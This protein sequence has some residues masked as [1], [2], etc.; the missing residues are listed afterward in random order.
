[1]LLAYGRLLS[2]FAYIGLLGY[3]PTLISAQC[4]GITHL[5]MRTTGVVSC[6][7]L[8]ASVVLLTHLSV[9]AH[10]VTVDHQGLYGQ[11][12]HC[13]LLE[14][15]GQWRCETIGREVNLIFIPFMLTSKINTKKHLPLSHFCLMLA[16]SF[17]LGRRGSHYN[18]DLFL[19]ESLSWITF[20]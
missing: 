11:Q 6:R 14:H 19:S 8:A 17:C 20:K 4:G 9:R 1:M 5:M 3:R 18:K 7:A 12:D 13:S 16:I 15:L 10:R 2:Y